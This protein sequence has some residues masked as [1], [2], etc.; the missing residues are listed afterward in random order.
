VN[1]KKEKVS[2]NFGWSEWRLGLE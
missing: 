1:S 2:W